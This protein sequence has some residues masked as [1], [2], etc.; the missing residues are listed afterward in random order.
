VRALAGAVFIIARA[1][2]ATFCTF[3][4]VFVA[5]RFAVVRLDDF[6]VVVFFFA[7]DFFIVDFFFAFDF[8]APAPRFIVVFFVFFEGFLP[9][10]FAM[11]PPSRCSH[12]YQN[13]SASHEKS[14]DSRH[15]DMGS[16]KPQAEGEN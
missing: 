14:R 3:A 7:D 1:C 2:F 15:A 8:A 5:G 11:G 6:A 13:R 12:V 10:F 9:A 4:I 16:A